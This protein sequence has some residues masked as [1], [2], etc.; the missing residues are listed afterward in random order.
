L[1]DVGDFGRHPP[2]AALHRV[3]FSKDAMGLKQTKQ[4]LCTL[5]GHPKTFCCVGRR[6]DWVLEE[7]INN[8][9]CSASLSSKGSAVLLAQIRK[10]LRA[11]N[12]VCRLL[13]HS[14]KGELNP[15]LEVAALSN[16]L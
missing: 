10:L 14:A 15:L 9:S 8:L 13:G 7:Q 1:K 16:G 4:I 2:V 3:G 5:S 6:H 11:S 12:R